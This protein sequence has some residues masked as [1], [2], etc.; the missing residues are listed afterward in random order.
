MSQTGI[1]VLRKIYGYK[2]STFPV[3]STLKGDISVNVRCLLNFRMNRYP[4]LK[5]Q[6]TNALKGGTRITRNFSVLGI[7]IWVRGVPK[8]QGYP[9]QCDTTI[10]RK[11]TEDLFW[12]ASAIVD[13]VLLQGMDGHIRR[14]MVLPFFTH[15]TTAAT[16]DSLKPEANMEPLQQFVSY[17]KENWIR[18]TV[19]P[20]SAG[21]YLCSQSGQTMT[22][23]AGIIA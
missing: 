10:K 6:Q 17:I 7:G 12:P 23:R 16:F 4:E 2:Y 21:A 8:T 9:N 18:S 22:L 20:P 11:A 13:E 3:I 14:M 1:P 5:K 19:I 15:E